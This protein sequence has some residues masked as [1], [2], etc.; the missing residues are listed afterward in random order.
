M[1]D[2]SNLTRPTF[3][4]DKVGGGTLKDSRDTLED[5]LILKLFDK[6]LYFYHSPLDEQE[7]SE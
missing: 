6:I 7:I 5:L 3:P 4:D 1:R 2:F